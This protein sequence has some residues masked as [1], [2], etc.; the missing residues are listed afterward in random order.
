MITDI[1][2]AT[3]SREVC[4]FP[5]RHYPLVLREGAGRFYWKLDNEGVTISGDLLRWEHDGATRERHFS[6]IASVHLQLGHVHKSGD[7]GTCQII[8]R[9]RLILTLQS[10]D[11]RGFADEG[12]AQNYAA[13]VRDLHARLSAL[14][15]KDIRYKAGNSERRHLIGMA[16]LAIAGL[17]FVGLP[18]A[19]FIYVRSWEA[20]GILG[21]G[22]AFVWPFARV[23]Q[24]NSPR[25][26]PPSHVPDD[27]LP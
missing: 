13:F 16:V 9:D 19:F 3:A 15:P 18:L 22:V 2:G 26:Y 17:F 10:T 25:D 20:F 8:F 1:T 6:E 21:A 27:L 7:I 4:T 12:R 5:D 24:R 11:A 23:L 14:G